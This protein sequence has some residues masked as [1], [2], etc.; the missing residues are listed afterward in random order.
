MTSLAD[1]DGITALLVESLLYRNSIHGNLRQVVVVG[2]IRG[3]G[4]R[5]ERRSNGLG[6]SLDVLG[7]SHSTLNA[8]NRNALTNVVG[9]DLGL[10]GLIDAHGAGA[11]MIALRNSVR[12]SQIGNGALDTAIVCHRT[13]DLR[14]SDIRSLA[15]QDLS[16]GGGSVASIGIERTGTSNRSTILAVSGK[17]F[18]QMGSI[19]GIRS[20]IDLGYAIDDDLRIVTT[21]FTGLNFTSHK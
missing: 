3:N 6:L 9:N 12:G 15:G 19:N 10:L 8:Q 14:A 7:T 21:I 17:A 20:Q 5:T 11:I 1:R 16:S 4:L 13:R 18:Q 2:R